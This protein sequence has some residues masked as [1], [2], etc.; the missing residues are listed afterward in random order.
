MNAHA[1]FRLVLRVLP[2]VLS[3]PFFAAYG[4]LVTG[5]AAFRAARGILGARF[6]F[7]S[8]LRCPR[9]HV[10]PVSGRYDCSGCRGSYFGWIGRCGICGAGADIT[11]CPEC[12]ISVRLPWEWA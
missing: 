9:G 6:I 1:I 2:H 7:V 10:V 4:A 11:P 12:G 3:S 8:A 5:V